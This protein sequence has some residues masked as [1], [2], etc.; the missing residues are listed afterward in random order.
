MYSS[1]ITLRNNPNCGFLAAAI[2]LSHAT[3]NC[4]DEV[5]NSH[6]Q[7]FSNYGHSAAVSR[8][9]LTDNCSRTSFSI[10]YKPLI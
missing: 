8:L 3:E 9:E 5:F 4:S 1:Q 7:M 6:D 2:I 10:S